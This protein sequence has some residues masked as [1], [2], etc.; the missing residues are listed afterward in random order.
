MLAALAFL[1]GSTFASASTSSFD[2]A[3]ALAEGTSRPHTPASL[4]ATS[5][6]IFLQIFHSVTI[7]S[8]VTSLTTHVTTLAHA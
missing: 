8:H 6:L 1:G 7:L 4:S 3:A 2:L 5:A